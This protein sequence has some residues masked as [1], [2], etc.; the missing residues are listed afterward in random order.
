MCL[1]NNGVGLNV[2]MVSCDKGA[3]GIPRN[4]P[5]MASK[6][7]PHRCC[8][9]GTRHAAVGIA[10]AQDVLAAVLHAPAAA[11]VEVDAHACAKASSDGS[12]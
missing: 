7:A 8:I 10:E 4:Q 3:S 11:E 1:N 12:K 9:M 2:R 6:R 5:C